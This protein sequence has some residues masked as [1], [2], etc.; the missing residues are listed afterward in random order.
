MMSQTEIR[1]DFS[2][3]LAIL[4]KTK[5]DIFIILLA[6]WNCYAIPFEVAFEPSVS[7]LFLSIIEHGVNFFHYF[8]CFY[9]YLF[10]VR[11]HGHF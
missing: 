2:S 5:F 3:D 7:F 8:K 6:V 1:I 11:H 9:R 10:L 4:G